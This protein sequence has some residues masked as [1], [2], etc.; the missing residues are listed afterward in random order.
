M[1]PKFD[2]VLQKLQYEIQKAWG[3]SGDSRQ[4]K[5]LA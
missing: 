5:T 2:K 3:T 1:L 4:A